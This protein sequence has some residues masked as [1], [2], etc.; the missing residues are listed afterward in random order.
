MN[1][2]M[3]T[4]REQ[5]YVVRRGVFDAERCGR[6]RVIAEAVWAK[7]MAAD[8][9]SGRPGGDAVNMFH[10]KHPAYVRG[11]PADLAY[12]LDSGA[13]PTVLDF[14]RCI[15]G[16]EPLYYSN[17]LWFN[18]TAAS[19][20]GFW[21]RDSQFVFPDEAEERERFDACMSDFGNGVQIQIALVDSDDLEYV[22]GSHLRWDTP[23]EYRIRRADGA[24][25]WT[26]NDM[27]GAER[28][29]LRAGD[30]L[31]LNPVGLHRGRYHVDKLRR[32][33]TVTI[34]RSSRPEANSFNRQ[35]WFLEPG[36]LDHL[37]HGALAWYRRF[38]DA[39]RHSWTLPAPPVD[40]NTGMTNAPAI[41]QDELPVG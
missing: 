28:I 7:C 23:A 38:I 35:P 1:P 29:A 30:A 26:S 14:A 40:P 22:P 39:Y 12:L 4:W 9:L 10:C 5:G 17:S 36:Y 18:P 41:P 11:A 33:F 16:E 2:T 32:T 34:T 15:H 31:A 21:H 8:A 25:N 3:A 37:S 27:P 13:Q 20:D 19:R 6:M 24:K